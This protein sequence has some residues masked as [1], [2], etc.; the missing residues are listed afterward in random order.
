MLANPT[1][2]AASDAGRRAGVLAREEAFNTALAT[3]CAEFA[4]CRFDGGAVFGTSSTASD[5]STRDYLHP[6]LAGQRKLAQVNR[7]V[8]Y[9]GP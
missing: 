3:V 1:S 2:T 8:G 9:W 4:Q 6:W 5:V 7:S